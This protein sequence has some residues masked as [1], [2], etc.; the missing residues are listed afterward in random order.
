MLASFLPMAQRVENTDFPANVM[1]SFLLREISFTLGWEI[2]EFVAKWHGVLTGL[3]WQ[4]VSQ[5]LQSS[6][7][8]SSSGTRL[9]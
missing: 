1:I 6:G 5:H 2:T 4:A 3:G 8:A 7:P 9:Q